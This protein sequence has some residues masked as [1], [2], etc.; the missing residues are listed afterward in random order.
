VKS[1]KFFS[2]SAVAAMVIAGAMLVSCSSVDSI[3]SVATVNGKELG[4]AEFEDLAAMLNEAEIFTLTNGELTSEDARQVLLTMI[5]AEVV[6]GI[7]ADYDIE[8]T[9]ADR[10]TYRAQLQEG[11]Q[12]EGYSD[13]LKDYAINLYA[14]QG[15]L[16]NIEALTDAE[17]E[18]LYD[19]EPGAAGVM[20]LRHLV[21]EAEDTALEALAEYEGGTEFAEV[22][23]KYSTEPNAV[24]SGGAL[25][26]TTNDNDCISVVQ[27]QRQ[28]DMD[29]VR[30]ALTAEAGAVVGPIK[31]SFGYHLIE[32]R[33]FDDVKESLSKI[34]ESNTG[35]SLADAALL[36]SDVRV[37]SSFGKW[38]AS[39]GVIVDL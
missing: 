5:S 11:G 16:S 32:S 34:F 13:A 35:A 39:S 6:R 26:D 29:F 30:G 20:C 17:I 2:V 37:D 25:R 38:D 12:L 28:F 10:E 8:V 4:R 21:V 3:D 31:S 14:E 15:A 7:L 33:S 24:T 18:E 19:S 22:A 9:D 27:Y 36:N 23:G 1:K